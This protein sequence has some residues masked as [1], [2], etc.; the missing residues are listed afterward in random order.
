MNPDP[1]VSSRNEPAQLAVCCTPGCD[2]VLPPQATTGRPARYCSAACR[3]RAH[4]QRHTR[5]EPAV[6][7]EVDM[8]SASSR[9]RR[10]ESAW[11]V[12]LRRDQRT[13]IVTIGLSRPGADHLAEQIRDLLSQ[14][15]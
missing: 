7:V 15:T 2:G 4:R 3:M 13:V 10:P 9:G 8:G 12:R 1:R 11:L 5:P 6:T 14:R